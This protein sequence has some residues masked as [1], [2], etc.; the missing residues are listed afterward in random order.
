MANHINEFKPALNRNRRD[1]FLS[2]LDLY[3][4]WVKRDDLIAMDYEFIFKSLAE[5]CYL[6]DQNPVKQEDE[7]RA[8]QVATNILKQDKGVFNAHDA[9]QFGMIGEA[10]YNLWKN[11]PQRFG[12]FNEK[13]GSYVYDAFVREILP[14]SAK[15]D[16]VHAGDYYVGAF[17]GEGFPIARR[18]GDELQCNIGGVKGNVKDVTARLFSVSQKTEQFLA[19]AEGVL[20]NGTMPASAEKLIL[21]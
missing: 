7:N 20:F 12:F 15:K 18:V 4:A 1:H 16:P 6:I 10:H 2:N 21:A 9:M 14:I 19:D 3:A 13:E 11:F 17:D 8:I 5:D